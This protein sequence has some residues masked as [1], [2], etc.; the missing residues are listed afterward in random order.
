MERI[1]S[2]TRVPCAT[3]TSTW[4]SLETI[5][6][7]VCL[8]LRIAILLQLSRARLQ[9]GPLHWGRISD[10]MRQAELNHE[11]PDLAKRREQR[12]GSPR[13]E[14]AAQFA[15]A[16]VIG[17]ADA[18]LDRARAQRPR[19]GAI[20]A[21]CEPAPLRS[22]DRTGAVGIAHEGA[23]VEKRHLAVPRRKRRRGANGLLDRGPRPA[24]IKARAACGGRSRGGDPLQ[25]GYAL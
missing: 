22:P 11:R 10:R 21:S 18:G 20:V 7:G 17:L 4:R 12:A 19:A 9:G 1:A 24:A 8:F 3:R 23:L 6:S 5:S 13:S 16:G 14:H 2:V 25:F 15:D